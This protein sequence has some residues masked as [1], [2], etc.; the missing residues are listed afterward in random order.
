MMPGP[1]QIIACPAC[2]GLARYMTLASGNTFGARSWTDGKQVAPMLP[3]PP[4]VVRC[5]HCEACY[6]L[7]E[8]E[9]VGTV[10]PWRDGGE[11]VNPAWASAEEVEEPNEE[12]YYRA[13]EQGL[14]QNPTEEKQA[15]VL[16][17]WRR[18]DAFRDTPEVQAEGASNPSGPSRE[19]L[20]A[21]AQLLDERDRIDRLMKAEVLREL[22]EFESAKR[23][24][25]RVRAKSLA[26]AVLQIRS[27]CDRRDTLVR[28]LPV[29]E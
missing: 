24:L 21:L 26:T 23:L 29:D 27:L 8:A 4:A 10:D 12:D 3:R 16:A 14:A 22:G 18:N 17:W 15:R 2:Q 11:P 19:N 7:A 25:K 13:L 1:D 5:H 28:E 6:W 20:V 9:K